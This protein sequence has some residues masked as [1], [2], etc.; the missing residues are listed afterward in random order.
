MGLETGPTAMTSAQRPL[1]RL[2]RLYDERNTL[3]TIW[4]LCSLHESHRRRLASHVCTAP[5]AG[6]AARPVPCAFL[7]YNASEGRV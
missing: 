4:A 7:N 6:A 2:K 5:C 1:M 3:L